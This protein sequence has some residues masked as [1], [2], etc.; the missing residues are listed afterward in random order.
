M[1][2]QPNPGSTT[3]TLHPLGNPQGKGLVPIL[4]VWGQFRPE[5]T[6]SKSR[7]Q[8]FSDYFV[9]L[10]VLSANFNFKP[11][12]DVPYFLYLKHEQWKL[13]LIEPHQVSEEFGDC[14]GEARLRLD[15]TW[16]LTTLADF[17]SN[18]ELVSALQAFREGLE[19]HLQTDRTIAS[20]LPFFIDELPFYRRLAASALARS[21]CLS[22]PDQQLLLQ[23]A[24][25][26]VAALPKP[27]QLN[28]DLVV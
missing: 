16:Q 2:L 25:R 1:S 17:D 23:P 28:T 3:Q 9:S 27:D 21:F 12:V 11:V 6:G 22:C 20:T 5:T 4:E 19:S 26:F 13:S 15:M 18:P 14:L 24:N 8:L 10:L 7:E